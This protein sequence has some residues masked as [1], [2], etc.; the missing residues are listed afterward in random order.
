M[1]SLS[2]L[3]TAALYRSIEEEC[4]GLTIEIFII[5]GGTKLSFQSW[6]YLEG[7]QKWDQN[8]KMTYNKLE[9]EAKHSKQYDKNSDKANSTGSTSWKYF[10]KGLR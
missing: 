2:A 9:T 1:A 6:K 10:M 3:W 5:L 8:W 7:D 4:E